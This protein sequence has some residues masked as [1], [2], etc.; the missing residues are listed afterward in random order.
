MGIWNKK[1]NKLD[2]K[3]DRY[4]TVKAQEDQHLLLIGANSI[5]NL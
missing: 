2:H 4:H 5:Q 1:K 3:K